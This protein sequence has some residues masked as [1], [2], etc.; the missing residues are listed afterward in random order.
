MSAWAGLAAFV[1]ASAAAAGPTRMAHIGAAALAGAAAGWVAGFAASR[2]RP[3]DL[4]EAR[5]AKTFFGRGD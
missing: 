5:R 4:R 3:P 1:V 2:L